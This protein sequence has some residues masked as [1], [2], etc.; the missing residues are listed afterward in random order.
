VLEEPPQGNRQGKRKGS[1]F[2]LR[3]DA[4]V[5]S[6]VY[7]FLARMK[8]WWSDYS[9]FFGRFEIKGVKRTANEAASE[10]LTLGTGALVVLYAFALPAFYEAQGKIN[11]ADEY[12]VTFLDR[13]GNEIGKRGVFR[14]DS[15]ELEEV[16]KHM[17]QATLATEDRRFYDHFGVDIVGTIRALAENV[18]HSDVVQGGSSISQ[19]LAKNMY[20]TPERSLRRKIN[21]AFIAILLETRY[22]KDEILKLYFDRV[23]LGGGTKGVEAAAQFYFGK[24]VRDV[25]LAEAAMIAGM[26]KAP[27]RFAPHM[28]LAAARARA[29]QVLTN[30]VEAGHL[31][32]SQ[33]Y[34]ARTNPAQIVERVEASTPDWFLDWAFEEVKRLM[35]GKDEHILIART[36]VDTNLQAIA[37]DA[38]TST[39]K[40]HGRSRAFDNGAVVAMENDGAVRAMIGGADYGESQ[41]NRA[42]MAYRQPG[43]SFK[44]YVYLT[45]LE[46]GYNPTSIESDGF[47][48]C[49][50]W[51]PKNYSGGFRG[52]M[53]LNDAFARSTNTIAVKLSLKVGREKV[54]ETLQKMGI[55]YVRKTCSM[56][57]GDTGM[58]P[59]DHTSGYAHMASGGLETRPFGIEEIRTLPRAGNPGEI[60]Y[61]HERDAPER[62]QIFDPE[63][64]AQMNRMMQLVV[65]QGTG[66]AANLDYTH[67]IGKTGTSTAY[68]DAWFV[69]S[70]GQYTVGVWLGRDNFRPM[71]RVTGGS[72]PAQ[73]WQKF[74]L[75]AHDTD[76]VPLLPGLSPHPVQVAEQQRL[77]AAR[78][79][80][81][82]LITPATAESVKDMSE[83]T[84]GLLQKIGGLLKNSND[85]SLSEPIRQGR[86]A[87]PAEEA[88]EEIGQDTPDAEEEHSGSPSEEEPPESQRAAQ[89]TE[90]ER[91]PR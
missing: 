52:R 1:S 33:V 63:V 64:A 57:L 73:I 14:D 32:E 28:N 62:K 31:T 91:I 55:N 34:H 67:A 79:A 42:S 51:S 4:W 8:D 37:Q 88:A 17:I 54:L 66:R 25:T 19:Q 3:I 49:G 71:A 21:E 65:T 20:L 85:A 82:D 15:V 87:A 53:T 75:G 45:A 11:D 24:S 69:G 6:G 56:A 74:M 48:R 29:N 40:Q 76:N 89:T 72:F 47:V 7:G 41:F 80:N 5:D 39:V 2:F 61:S 84:R 68:R 22:T 9:T 27:S 43:S 81:P 59:L 77:E 36:T 26:Y 83:A 12:S 38:L 16:P 60:V 50:N 44:M 18:R 70:T 23:Y 10:A 30:M 35:R 86:P 58:T 78:I 90:P 13:Y 46:N